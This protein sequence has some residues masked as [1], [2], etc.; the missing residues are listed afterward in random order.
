MK[1]NTTKELIPVSDGV[2][3]EAAARLAAYLGPLLTLLDRRLDSRLVCTF[4]ATVVNIIRHR[5]R[6]LSLL[7]TELGELLTDG[8]HAPAGVKRLWRLLHS[9]KWA[10]SLIGDWLLA[11]ADRA[12]EAAIAKDGKAF[13]VL[14]GSG[15]EKPT[16]RKLQGLTKVRSANAALLWKAAGLPPMKRPVMVPGFGWVAAVIT[17]L[18]GSF[19]LASMHWFS[20]TAPT[21][22]AQKQREAEWGVL[23]PLLERWGGKVICVLDRGFDSHPFL[24]QLLAVMAR[25]IVRWRANYALIGPDGAEKRAGQLTRWLRSQW[26]MWLFDGR[27]QQWFR[28]GVASLPVRLPGYA[29]PLW[30]VVARRKGKHSWY[31]LSTEDASSKAGALG[32][33]QAYARRWQVEVV[34]TQMTKARVRTRLGGRDHVADLHPLVFDD[35]PIDE[36]LNQLPALGKVSFGQSL[37]NSAAESFDRLSNRCDLLPPLGVG[38]QLP[39]LVA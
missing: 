21:G 23:R 33:V 25:F 15:V 12:V 16:A 9:Q 32:V 24:G 17:G 4:A 13:L 26:R 36:Q 5:D 31:F 2:S 22:Q 3:Q 34:F 35:H 19:T 1:R 37:P 7:L 14:D 6:T 38:L 28:L 8:A 18:G 30:L 39:D 29:V 11:D 20:P 27:R 10:A